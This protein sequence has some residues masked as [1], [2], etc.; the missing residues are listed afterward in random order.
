M[1][2]CVNELMGDHSTTIEWVVK[3]LRI[4]DF[5]LGLKFEDKLNQVNHLSTKL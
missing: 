2:A 4:N 5:K 1:N 3:S